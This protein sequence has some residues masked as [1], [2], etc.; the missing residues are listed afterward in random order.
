MPEG[1]AFLKGERRQLKRWLEER[2]T[3]GDVTAALGS[4]EEWLGNPEEAVQYLK[5]SV[6]M[7][8]HSVYFTLVC[9]F[10]SCVVLCL[11]HCY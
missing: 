3:S 11:L 6:E 1:Q 7:E 9:W 5:L 4:I 2:E 8:P 10:A